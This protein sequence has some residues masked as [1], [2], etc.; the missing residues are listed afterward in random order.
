MAPETA[1]QVID[2][3]TVETAVLVRVK[4]GADEYPVRSHLD[5]PLAEVEE[6]LA[7]Y[8]QMVG[9]PWHEQLQ[10]GRRLVRILCPEMPDEKLARMTGRQI[11]SFIVQVIGVG[12]LVPEAPKE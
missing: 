9:R 1:V 4:V 11:T 2:L 5:I 10:V 8:R 7:L 12:A 3:D 6:I